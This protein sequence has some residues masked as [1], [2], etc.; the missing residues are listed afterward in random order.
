MD[1]SFVAKTV[2]SSRLTMAVKVYLP[3]AKGCSG[4]R[5]NLIFL[6]FGGIIGTTSS[7]E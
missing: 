5:S 3:G 1:V 4:A 2:P 7:G 6:A